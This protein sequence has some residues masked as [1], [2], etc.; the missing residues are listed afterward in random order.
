MPTPQ[1]HLAGDDV[2]VFI[3]QEDAVAYE[4]IDL[5]NPGFDNPRPSRP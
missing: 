3:H 1:V 5:W 2:P 4:D